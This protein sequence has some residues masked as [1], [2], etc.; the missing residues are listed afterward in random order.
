VLLKNGSLAKVY[1][2]SS[3]SWKVKYDADDHFKS[4]GFQ[5]GFEIVKG[6]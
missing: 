2:F 1:I 5:I 4:D 6:I 3:R